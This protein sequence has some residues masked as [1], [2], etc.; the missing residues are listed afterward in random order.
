MSETQK[1]CEWNSR[2]VPELCKWNAFTIDR[3]LGLWEDG[4]SMGKF[5]PLF[6]RG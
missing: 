3:T 1:E 4:D 6:R 2:C 5:L